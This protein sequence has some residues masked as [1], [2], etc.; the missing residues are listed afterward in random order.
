MNPAA[1]AFATPTQERARCGTK[2]K[3]PAPRPVASAVASAA[4]KTARTLGSFITQRLSQ[5]TRRYQHVEAGN[6]RYAPIRVGSW[7]RIV[8]LRRATTRPAS[9]PGA[10]PP[11]GGGATQ[12]G[13]RCARS[14]TRSQSWSSTFR[15]RRARRDPRPGSAPAGTRSSS[16]RARTRIV[17]Q[18]RGLST[19]SS[20]S[21]M[22][23]SRQRRTS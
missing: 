20:T 16:R 4:A 8:S 21:G 23:P 18:G 14:A 6:N 2:R 12:H 5:P 10:R 13:V 22:T 19:A 1:S 7:R 9:Q 11:V 15:R 17:R 3:G